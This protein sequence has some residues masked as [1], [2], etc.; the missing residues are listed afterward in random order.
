MKYKTKKMRNLDYYLFNLYLKQYVSFYHK[1][2]LS[3]YKV[4]NKTHMR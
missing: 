3:I 2:S 1:I 4:K